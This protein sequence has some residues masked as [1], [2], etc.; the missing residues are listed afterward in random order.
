MP[1]WPNV[2]MNCTSINQ[3]EIYPFLGAG[4]YKIALKLWGAVVSKAY[5]LSEG[6][7]H[8]LI[9]AIFA[10]VKLDKSNS[11]STFYNTD[12]FFNTFLTNRP[13]RSLLTFC[14]VILL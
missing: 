8:M 7:H 13:F 3:W 4:F 5:N 6:C 14:I 11:T 9:E 12:F 1:T 10:L 2:S